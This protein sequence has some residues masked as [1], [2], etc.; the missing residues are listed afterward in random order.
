MSTEPAIDLNDWTFF[1]TDIVASRV[2]TACGSADDVL[3][4]W[5]A[6]TDQ[7]LCRTCAEA[8]RQLTWRDVLEAAA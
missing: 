3:E 2:C 4:A 7:I 1:A 6:G 8:W 5:V